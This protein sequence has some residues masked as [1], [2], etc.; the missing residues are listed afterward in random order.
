M[1]EAAQGHGFTLRHE[2]EPR[3]GDYRWI[4]IWHWPIRAMHW[5]AAGCIVVLVV[6]GFYIGRPYF[7]SSG[8]ASAH[9]LM[10]RMRLAHFVALEAHRDAF[11]QEPEAE[12]GTRRQIERAG[13]AEQ[14]RRDSG[15]DENEGV[16]QDLPARVFAVSTHAL[17]GF[18]ALS[19]IRQPAHQHAQPKAVHD[20]RAQPAFFGVHR[21]DQGQPR[22]VAG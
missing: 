18:Q 15:D 4:Y 6:T 14:H 10:G 5:I 2:V 21:T 8:E 11:D 3:S 9:F 7:M 20:L 17:V 16:G 1:T 22:A 12:P 19:G 13:K